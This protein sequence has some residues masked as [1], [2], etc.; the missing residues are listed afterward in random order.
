LIWDAAG[1]VGSTYDEVTYLNVAAEWWRTGRQE[2]IAR[3][4]SPLT[5]W[6]LQQAAVLAWLD[7][8]GRGGW[9]DHPEPNRA[10][11]LPVVRRGAVWIWVVGLV[12]TAV[13]AGMVYGPA[14][15]AVAAGLFAFGPNL[16]AHGTLITMEAPVTACAAVSGLGAWIWL[17]RGW[18]GGWWL[19]AVAA[20]VG[21]SCKFTILAFVPLIGVGQAWVLMRRGNRFWAEVVPRVVG[22]GVGYLVVMAAVDGVITGGAAI[23][24]SETRGEHPALEAWVGPELSRVLGGFLE[25]RWPQ[26]FVAFVRQMQHQASGGPSYLLGERRPRGWFHYYLVALAVK[27]PLGVLMMM[28]ARAVWDRRV[29]RGRPADGLLLVIPL[30]LLG[31][32]SIGSTRNYGV[33]YLLPAAPAMVV[34]MAGL[35]R[36][37]W[38]GRVVCGLGLTMTGLATMGIH[39]HEL[40]FFNRLAGGPAGGR[41]ILADSNLDW[42]QGAPELARL[43]RQRPELA[44]L[45]TYYFGQGDPGDYGVQGR[46]IVIDASSDPSGMPRRIEAETAYVGVS[47]SLIWGPW[48]PEGVFE[49][50]REIEPVAWTGDRT[51]A[52]YRR[53]DV[54]AE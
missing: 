25:Q 41:W 14:A 44:D 33:R 43:Q 34:W 49:R 18:R 48:G 28:G 27:L 1:R 45:T 36:A 12:A 35:V 7:A 16:V 4:G 8:S 52:V 26:D 5:F 21:L 42:G 46:R 23:P 31:L 17:D 30:G 20:G 11:L 37:G 3:M 6:K 22:C 24:L 19:S 39:P 50:L 40:T 15:R 53:E 47:S 9:I 38:G 10:W 32:A 51:I 13:W 29:A 2:S 54:V